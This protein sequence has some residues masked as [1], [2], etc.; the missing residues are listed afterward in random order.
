MGLRISHEGDELFFGA[1]SAFNRLRK[2]VAEAWGGSF[3][4]HDQPDLDPESWYAPDD[5][6]K[7]CPGLVFLMNHSDCDGEIP[8]GV[9]GALAEDLEQIVDGVTTG[10]GGHLERAGGAQKIVRT[11]ID[12]CKRCAESETPITFT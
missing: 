5:G 2:A 10:G 8:P 3:P 12:G 7:N 11:L 9:A 6:V 1:Y 4:P